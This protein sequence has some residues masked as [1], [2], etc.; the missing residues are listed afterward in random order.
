[1]SRIGKMPVTIPPGV[2][3]NRKDSELVIKGPR[4]TLSYT[5]PKE[6]AVAIE[7]E[8][9]VV[10]ALGEDRKSRSLHGLVRSIIFN[11]ITGVT[12][13]FTRVLEIQGVGYRADVQDKT[14]VINLGY[15]QPIRYELPQGVSVRVDRQTTITLEGIEKELLGMVA[16]KIRGFRPSEPYKHKGIRYAGEKLRKKV[17]KSG[18]R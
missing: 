2:Q 12:Q 17:G 6:V 11:K 14:L 18:V 13:G 8:N 15:S 16:S 7:S 4:G 5:I 1:M 9:L 10:R 3:V